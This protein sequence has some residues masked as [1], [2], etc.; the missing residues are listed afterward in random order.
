M[1]ACL[2]RRRR[3]HRAGSCDQVEACDLRR[4][5]KASL[6]PQHEP[7][8]P[9]RSRSMPTP[10]R[11]RTRSELWVIYGS[12]VGS[13]GR[14]TGSRRATVRTLRSIAY[15]AQHARHLFT[16][17]QARR[18]RLTR[19]T[20]ESEYFNDPRRISG[21]PRRPCPD[22]KTF[23]FTTLTTS[24]AFRREECRRLQ[25]SRLRGQSGPIGSSRR[26]MRHLHAPRLRSLLGRTSRL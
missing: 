16:H 17:R 14:H 1:P 20:P 24:R 11:V 12:G 18:F 6:I 26:R 5:V 15:D 21:R 7:L 25:P 2:G 10:R 8:R 23:A 9:A 19:W 3:Y 22:G 4:G 13:G